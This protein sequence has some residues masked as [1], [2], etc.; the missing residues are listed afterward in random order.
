MTYAETS[1]K[2]GIFKSIQRPLTPK[3]ISLYKRSAFGLELPNTGSTHMRSFWSNY[4][5]DTLIVTAFVIVWLALYSVV[6]YS[7]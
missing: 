7:L 1:K 3:K 5:E 6:A 2:H 4:R